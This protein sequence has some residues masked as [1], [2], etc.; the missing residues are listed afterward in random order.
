MSSRAP[1]SSSH[2]R[3]NTPNRRAKTMSES[4]GDRS[5]M[6]RRDALRAGALGAAGLAAATGALA[7]R[8]RTGETHEVYLGQAHEA[9]VSSVVGDIRPGGFDPMA[10]LETFDYG[11]VSRAASGQTVRDYSIVAMD[12]EIEVAPGV[13]F[14]AWTYNGQV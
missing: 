3:A 5:T 10:F 13:F 6:T 11:V 1:S 8:P 12:K 7:I 4:G 14:P 2:Y 9:H